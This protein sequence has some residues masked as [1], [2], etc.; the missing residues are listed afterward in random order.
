MRWR[1]GWRAVAVASMIGWL[2][3]GSALAQEGTPAAGEDGNPRVVQPRECQVEPRSG[4][5]IAQMLQL[6]GEG[7]PPPSAITITAPLGSVVDAATAIPIKEAAREIIA[8]FNAQ[9]LS[10]AAALMSEQGLQ[11]AF[12]GVTTSPEARAATKAQLAATPEPRVEEAL[13]R[14]LAVTDESMLPDGRIA[15][16]VIVSD[17][18]LPPPGSEALLFT[19][20]QQDGQWLLDDLVRF[21]VVPAAPAATPPPA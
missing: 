16:F 11:R 4:D 9:D 5:E 13:T 6:D 21:A 1:N 2:P 7:V 3:I 8:C 15:A 10:R 18:L 14:L 17:P 20:V 19:F 12:W